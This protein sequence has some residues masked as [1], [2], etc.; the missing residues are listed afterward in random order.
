VA[1]PAVWTDQETAPLTT[2][3]IEVLGNCEG[4]P[5]TARQEVEPNLPRCVR[6]FQV[7][8]R[9]KIRA[10]T[11]ETVKTIIQL[12]SPIAGIVAAFLALWVYH[13][14]SRRERARWAESLYARF[15]E[16]SELKALRDQLDC[17]PGEPSIASLVAEESSALT[18]YL[19]FFEFVAYLQSSKQL[20]Y[21]DV[22]AMFGYYLGCLRRHKELVAYIYDKDKGFEYLRK[23]LSH[24]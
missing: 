2:P 24:A 11:L 5:A 1:L 18:D 22:Q 7:R 19:N 3:A 23:I 15:Y 12:V 20:S 21:R 9:S 16:K 6:Y 8:A 4:D 13:S 14:N 10:M 17:A